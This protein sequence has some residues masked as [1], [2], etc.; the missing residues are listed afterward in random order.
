M[1]AQGL[2][3]PSQIARKRGWSRQYAHRW[4]RTL[5][6]KHGAQLVVG[7]H[8]RLYISREELARLAVNLSSES[9]E[10]TI[11]DLLSRV[12]TLESLVNGLSC[13]MADTRRKLQECLRR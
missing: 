9:T 4:L 11:S 5:Q 13:D 6:R 12:E 3:S 2:L 7:E 8:G 10:R 1:F